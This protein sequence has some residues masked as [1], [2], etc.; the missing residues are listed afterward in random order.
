MKY[1]VSYIDTSANIVTVA[2]AEI[3]ISKKINSYEMI[4]E[5]QTKLKYEFGLNNPIVINFIRLD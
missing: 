4:L 5:I 1:F 2:N 3:N